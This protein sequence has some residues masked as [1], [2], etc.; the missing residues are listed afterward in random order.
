MSTASMLG[1]MNQLMRVMIP[2]NIRPRRARLWTPV[3]MVYPM[4]DITS[5]AQCA[6]MDAYSPYWM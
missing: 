2:R 4:V 3:P 1:L 6:R 5:I